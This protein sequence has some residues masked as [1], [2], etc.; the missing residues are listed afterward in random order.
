MLP[1]P[2]SN[3][4]KVEME[5]REQKR[6]RIS[7]N[8][9]ETK[10]EGDS[11]FSPSAI[12]EAEISR[13]KYFIRENWQYLPF[14]MPGSC[15]E[16]SPGLEALSFLNTTNAIYCI[17][18]RRLPGRAAV[19]RRRSGRVSSLDDALPSPKGGRYLLL[20]DLK[21]LHLTHPQKDQPAPAH[22]GPTRS[23]Q[24]AAPGLGGGAKSRVS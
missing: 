12:A 21:L 24:R 16:R 18:R 22:H 6:P 2:A 13:D 9:Q 17:H 11:C 10:L 14:Y 3:L 4:Q 7:V 1:A 23:T 15:C 19:R 8:M 20:P 5:I